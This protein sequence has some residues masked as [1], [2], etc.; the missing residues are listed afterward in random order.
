MRL[1]ESAPFSNLAAAFPRRGDEIDA[2]LAL[3]NRAARD[4]VR[5]Y[6]RKALPGWVA[7]LADPWLGLRARPWL[8]RSV[9]EVL[10]G[11]TDDPRL[12]AVL[13]AQW[14]YY[15]TPPSRA[16]FAIQA[17]ITRHFLH[18][19]YY[20]VGG[21]QEIAR[22]L[23]RTVAAAGGWTRVVAEVEEVLVERG[24][25]AGVRLAGGEVLRAPRVVLASGVGTAVRRLLPEHVR[26]TPWAAAL[27]ALEPGPA[28][29]C[30]YLG[31]QGGDPRRA[32]ASGAN[33]W[34]YRTWSHD[35][36]VWDVAPDQPLPP[37]PVLYVSFPSLKDPHHDPGPEQR[38]TAEVVTFVPWSV[39]RR[40]RTAARPSSSGS[41]S[42]CCGRCSTTCPAW[43]RWSTMW[44]CRR[45][46]RRISSAVPWPAP[47]TGWRRRRS[48]LP[49]LA[50]VP[51][52]RYAVCISRVAT[53]PPVA[54]SVPSAAACWR[55][56]RCSRGASSSCC[57]RSE[58]A[59]PDVA[60]RPCAA[61]T[62]R[63]SCY[64]CET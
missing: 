31:L 15:G 58:A 37:A 57:A 42:R 1:L 21:A 41:R 19:G 39:S 6:G 4:T 61:A 52:R 27:R 5:Y 11:I 55:P 62:G 25:A 2:F 35:S 24:R 44:N 30:L 14:G 59:S 38:H 46:C 13:T 48:A 7:S 54:S 34:I 40:G 33:H 3:V 64:H 56:W 9:D 49:I 63:S 28:H 51:A 18:G 23:C 16:P 60:E 32:G 36:A 53:S 50:C 12:R 26:A 47:S 8:R 29:V 20:P 10:S 43:R 17:L 45:R 22:C